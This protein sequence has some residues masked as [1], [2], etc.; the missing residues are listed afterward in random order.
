MITTLFVLSLLY[1]TCKR[2]PISRW[3]NEV[4]GI[5]ELPEPASRPIDSLA[6]VGQEPRDSDTNV[7]DEQEDETKRVA[8]D[9]TVG[10]TGMG[11]D[12]E[13]VALIR[14]QTH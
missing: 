4:F 12:N 13:Y 2:L 1:W 7:G 3:I 8:Q 6:E 9:T 11:S 14:R 10:C 5:R